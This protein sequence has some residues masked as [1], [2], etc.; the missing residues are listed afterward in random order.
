MY[1]WGK[2][3]GYEDALAYLGGVEI[4]EADEQLSREIFKEQVNE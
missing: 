4:P 3:K 1:E 2:D